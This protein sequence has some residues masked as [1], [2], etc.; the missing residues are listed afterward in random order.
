MPATPH[1]WTLIVAAIGSAVAVI[2]TMVWKEV[3]TKAAKAIVDYSTAFFL[4]PVRVNEIDKRLGQN[5]KESVFELLH[6][7]QAASKASLLKERIR[8][9]RDHVM[10]WHSDSQGHCTWASKELQ[11]LVGSTFDE[12]FRGM[13]WLNLFLPAERD[14]IEESWNNSIQNGDPFVVKSNYVHADGNIIPVHIEAHP[15]PDGAVIGLVNR[16]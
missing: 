10:M 13:N 11:K 9:D 1:F 3:T 4:M 15:L 8:A 6:S 16:L 7:L 2:M 14:Q 12:R 5:G